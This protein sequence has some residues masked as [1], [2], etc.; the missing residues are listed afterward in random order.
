MSARPAADS[1]LL[2]NAAAVVSPSAV[3]VSPPL[4]LYAHLPWCVR[5]CPYCDFNAHRAPAKIPEREYVRALLADAEAFLPAA[6]G[7]RV[8]SVF[9][10]GGTPSLFSPESM[11]ELLRGLRA[12]FA[13]SPE[14]EI[15]MEAN[16]G[17]AD[18]AKFREFAAAGINR[19][20]L[21]AQSFDDRALAALGR[22]HDGKKS[23]E[24][25]AAVA[26][27][28]DNF[29]I[30]LMHALPGHS[31]QNAAEDLRIALSFSPPHLSLYQLTLEPG[32]PFYRRPPPLPSAD[33][34]ADIGDAVFAAAEE[35]GFRRYEVSAFARA[36]RECRHNLNY[37]RFGDYIGIG[38][39][40]HGKM[41]AA[42]KIVRAA[43]VKDP[44]E[45]MRRALSENDSAIAE[46][47][48]VSA[49]DAAFEFMMNALRL[50]GG[51]PPSLLCERAGVPI[52]AV[53]HILASC[54]E[55]GL[56]FRG[57]HIVRPTARGLRHLNEMLT[58]FLPE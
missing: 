46:T 20:S 31:A 18:A 47:R 22:I 41:T 21:G 45:Y 57:A 38:A 25:A 17:A 50:S 2:K 55:D 53:E 40:A 12:L 27:A 16:P 48:E 10:G 49:R 39:G 51:F 44:R 5:R 19:L 43:R 15:T 28:F 1:V 58:R 42:G 32:T 29:N 52:N 36:G 26:D 30:D 14:C 11:D 33:E 54:E 8:L 35:A 23:R 34:S 24:A 4:S 9:V 3:S 13:I 6:W 37:W 56:L 7:R